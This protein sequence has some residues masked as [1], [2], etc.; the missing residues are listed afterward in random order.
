MAPSN[1]SIL[2]YSGRTNAK[3]KIQ[4]SQDRF[5]GNNLHQPVCERRYCW[6]NTDRANLDIILEILKEET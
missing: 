6:M 3:A 5:L 4:W 1:L 2:L